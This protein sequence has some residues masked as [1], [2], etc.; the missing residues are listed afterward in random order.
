MTNNVIR[1]EKCANISIPPNGHNEVTRTFSTRPK[2][3]MQLEFKKKT[4][5]TRKQTWPSIALQF[6]LLP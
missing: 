1:Q 2:I 3:H 5:I 6:V 4:E